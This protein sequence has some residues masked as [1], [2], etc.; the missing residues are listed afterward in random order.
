M[1][2]LYKQPYVSTWNYWKRTSAKLVY[3]WLFFYCH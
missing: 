3:H 1:D 2:A